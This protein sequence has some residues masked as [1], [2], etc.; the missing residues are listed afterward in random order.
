MTSYKLSPVYIVIMSELA[1]FW[2]TELENVVQRMQK[3]GAVKIVN[4]KGNEVIIKVAKIDPA[5]CA[6]NKFCY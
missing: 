5:R 1:G 3:G 4:H 2:E 6:S